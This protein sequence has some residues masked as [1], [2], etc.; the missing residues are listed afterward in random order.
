MEFE[1]ATLEH[2]IPLSLGGNWDLKN[3]QL[4]CFDCNNERGNADF[5]Q[6]RDWRRGLGPKPQTHLESPETLDDLLNKLSIQYRK[7]RQSELS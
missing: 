5:Y 2:L 1:G 6:Y 3:L 4:S 7:D